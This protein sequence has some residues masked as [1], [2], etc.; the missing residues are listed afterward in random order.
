[1]VMVQR[2]VS[3]LSLAIWGP[4]LGTWKL[5]VRADSLLTNGEAAKGKLG[6]LEAV[7]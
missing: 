3:A 6:A 7:F 1:M 5:R 2:S 4:F